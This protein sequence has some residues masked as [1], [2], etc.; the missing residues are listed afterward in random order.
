MFRRAFSV[1]IMEMAY[2]FGNGM[3]NTSV[4]SAL[5]PVKCTAKIRFNIALRVIS[6]IVGGGYVVHTRGPRVQRFEMSGG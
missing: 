6:K 4:R 3:L 1:N 2:S 5:S